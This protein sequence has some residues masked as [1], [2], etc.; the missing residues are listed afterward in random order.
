MMTRTLLLT[1]AGLLVLQGQQPAFVVRI[2]DMGAFGDGRIDDAAAIQK[3]IDDSPDSSIIDFSEGRTYLIGRT[4]RLQSNRVY[5]GASTIVMA[6][7]A[8]PGSAMLQMSYGKSRSVT[9]DGLTLDAREVGGILQLAVG[10]GTDSPASRIIIRRCALLNSGGS[11]GEVSES[12]IYTP[13][14]LHSSVISDNRFVNCRTCIHIVNPY[15]VR[16]TNNEF[17][18]TRGGNA[19]SVVTY[20]FSAAYGE[21]LEIRGNHGRNIKRMAIELVGAQPDTR[22][23]NPLVADNTFSD[24]QEMPANDAYGI[25]VAVGA[26]A[27][28]LRNTLSGRQGGYG[29]EVGSHGSLVSGNIVSGFFHGIVIQGQSDVIITSNTISDQ[30]D[31]GIIFS[32]AGPNQRAQVSDNRIVNA[33]KFGIGMSP[34]NYGGSVI[35][36][37]T[38]EREAGR[39][40]EDAVPQTFIGIKLDSGPASPVKVSGNR[41]A[42]TATNPPPRFD[43][44]GIGFFGGFPGSE[45][46]D[47][48]VESKSNSPLGTGLFFWF[49]PYAEGSTISENKFINLIRVT[50]GF[51]SPR[52]HAMDNRAIRVPQSDPNIIGPPVRKSR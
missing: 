5:R 52:V 47:N 30:V 10:G 4:L 35:E 1:A 41:I 24:W 48:T 16:I 32:N 39:F 37:N 17:D 20:N 44:I 13:V 36:G 11:G 7:S 50:N 26:N 15:H 18:T 23:N 46:G 49:S 45:F 19:I 14:G 6:L 21:G 12:A 27:R 38:I 34:N 28:I 2:P 42:Q 51:T 8:A 25:S 31:S 33:R 43:F 3:A 22:M 29:I 9:L 40:A